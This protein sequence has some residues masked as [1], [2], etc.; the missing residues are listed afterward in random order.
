MRKLVIVFIVVMVMSFVFSSIGLAKEFPKGYKYPE[1]F[2]TYPEKE[3]NVFHEENDNQIYFLPDTIRIFPNYITL[4][5]ARERPKEAPYKGYFVI[6][7]KKNYDGVIEYKQVISY[8]INKNT[9][10]C[11]YTKDFGFDSQV[12]TEIY[13]VPYPELAICLETVF[14]YIENK[15]GTQEILDRGYS[16]TM[17]AQSGVSNSSKS[18]AGYNVAQ[19]TPAVA[20]NTK[21]GNGQIKGKNVNMREAPSTNS[22]VIYQFP[23]GEHVVILDKK[24]PAPDKYP[25][26]KVSYGD[27]LGWVYGQFLK[28]N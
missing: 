26:Y 6:A 2:Y 8:V 3:Y 24:A 15:D 11:E 7:A 4:T 25:W 10:K 13:K 14:D 28:T 5:I 22:K 9:G 19:G 18:N 16:D 27:M 23:G 12:W 1:V 21:L 17:A 20:G